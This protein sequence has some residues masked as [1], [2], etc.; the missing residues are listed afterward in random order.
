MRNNKILIFFL[1]SICYIIYGSNQTFAATC[2]NGYNTCNMGGSRWDIRASLTNAEVDYFASVGV[3]YSLGD[4]NNLRKPYADCLHCHD[5]TYD[6]A[7]HVVNDVDFRS[8]GIRLHCVN[9]NGRR[10]LPKGPST[11]TH[12]SWSCQWIDCDQAE[13]DWVAGPLWNPAD[14]YGTCK[15]TCTQRYVCTLQSSQGSCPGVT[16][17]PNPSK[18]EIKTLTMSGCTTDEAICGTADGYKFAYNDTDWLSTHS[19]CNVG[20]S[21]P[22]SPNFPSLNSTVNWTCN[23]G[24]SVDHCSAS[25][26]TTTGCTENC[27]GS[28]PYCGD[29]DVDS[30]ET[31]DDGN[32][33]DGDAC[34]N[35]CTIPTT[36]YC[37]DGD[38]NVGEDCDDGNNL[39]GDGC[40]S[41]CS[42]I[43]GGYCGDGEVQKP[44]K[45]GV[46]EAC[47]DSNN[48]SDDGCTNSCML[49]PTGRPEEKTYCGNGK[50]DRPN[51]F[52]FSEECDDGNTNSNDTCTNNCTLPHTSQPGEGGILATSSCSFTTSG[53]G[54]ANGS[55]LNTIYATITI[56]TQDNKNAVNLGKPTEMADLSRNLTDRV[57]NKGGSSLTFTPVTS[58]IIVPGDGQPHKVKIGTVTSI[59]PFTSCG[60]KVSFK[61]AGKTITLSDVGY[62]FRKPFIGQLTSVS[63]VSLGTKLQ[64]TLSALPVSS[65]S[66]YSLGLKVNNIVNLGEN[67]ALQNTKLLSYTGIGPRK[68]ETRINSSVYATAL[69][70]Q[71]GVQ[72]V[73][74]VISYKVGGKTV[75][76]YLSK[77]DYANDRTPIDKSG[78][79]FLGVKIIG[80]LQGAGKY[81][82]TGQGKNIANLYPSN[83]RTE[84]RKRAYDY[85]KKMTNRQVLNRVKYVVG[86]DAVISGD[87][88]YETLIVKDG[89]VVIS[90]DLNTSNKKLGIIILKDGYDVNTG[91]N[92]KG[93]ILVKPDVTKINAM[94]YADGAFMSAKANEDKVY[95]P[96]STER[97]YAL[98][99]Q[100]TMN[101]VLFTRNTIGGAQYVGGY[102]TIPGG[103][104]TMSYDK[105]MVYDLN[106]IR[107]GNIGCYDSNSNGNCEDVNLGEIKEGFI[108]KYDSR[109][110]TNP[111]K[112]FSK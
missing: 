2:A 12:E 64:Y 41:T 10:L 82:F 92:Y 67:I 49:P 6:F 63:N 73:L 27:G 105:S 25:R 24:T 32:D 85:T 34:K 15:S 98:Q 107:R 48:I 52:G 50:I 110:Q 76:Y 26:G 87:L 69:N 68:F 42:E 103:I 36:F 72:V 20:S 60:N 4:L 109:I 55:D 18:E 23:L 16:A 35:N 79:K 66:N 111:P 77:Y 43:G 51:Y 3:N 54:Y 75:R 84:I 40:S 91:Y 56:K 78:D 88:D 7:D 90:G 93:N 102:Y 108:I 29:G 58:D 31:C 86:E 30:G 95:Y 14:V 97:T 11:C 5:S 61:L 13:T 101:G 19:W 38:V 89:N 62:N 99:R 57:Y 44:N 1:V 80:G 46:N 39:G 8:D 17:G 65:Y 70:N 53:S 81:E 106:Y 22:S 59:T 45:Y 96:D 83:L 104:R 21:S 33:Y 74:P 94:I 9:A 112:L 37:G 28:D 71:P 47:D 100:L